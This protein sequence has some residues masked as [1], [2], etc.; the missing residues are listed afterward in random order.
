MP[1]NVL[2]LPDSDAMV[3]FIFILNKR[4]NIASG[5]YSEPKHYVDDAEA[6]VN[7]LVQIVALHRASHANCIVRG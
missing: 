4:A 1:P 7:T 3:N 6:D 2:T 5:G